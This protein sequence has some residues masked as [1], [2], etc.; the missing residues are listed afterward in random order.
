MGNRR[1]PS[2]VGQR[3]VR[4]TWRK[5]HPDRSRVSLL[6]P[7]VVRHNPGW[8]QPKARMRRL[9]PPLNGGTMQNPFKFGLRLRGQVGTARCRADCAGHDEGAR[10]L[11][12]RPHDQPGGPGWPLAHRH[13]W[14]PR[15][16][17]SEDPVRPGLIAPVGARPDLRAIP[18]E[19][20]EAERLATVRRASSAR[21]PSRASRTP[22]SPPSSCLC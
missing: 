6:R 3:S 2:K 22:P 20:I 12:R 14:R 1:L 21:R 10:R 13:P 9:T 8:P 5:R 16:G 17:S 18:G 15:S 11:W 4:W 19:R 7:L